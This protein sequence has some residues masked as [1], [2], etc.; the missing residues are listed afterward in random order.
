VN[1]FFLACHDFQ[2]RKSECAFFF[3]LI[4]FFTLPKIAKKKKKMEKKRFGE[5]MLSEASQER[6][7]RL[8]PRAL[9]LVLVLVGAA[10]FGPDLLL[11]RARDG[12]GDAAFEPPQSADPWAIGAPTAANAA[13]EAEA[14]AAVAA[15][16]AA[17]LAAQSAAEK[18]ATEE[19][20]E[21]G[22][23]RSDGAVAEP[24][25]VTGPAR[26]LASRVGFPLNATMAVLEYNTPQT[27]NNTL[28][29]YVVRGL[30][31]RF[32]RRVLFLQ[33]RAAVRPMTRLEEALGRGAGLEIWGS[34]ENRHVGVALRE[35]VRAADTEF[36][37]FLEKDFALVEPAPLVDAALADAVALLA[38]GV[39]DVVRL[40]SRRNPGNPEF[41]ELHFKG[42]EETVFK[43]QRNLLCNFYHFIRRPERRW[44]QHFRVCAHGWYCVQSEF[45]NWTNNPVLF[46]RSWWLDNIAVWVDA[47]KI[48]APPHENHNFEATLNVV[49]EAWSE[50]N[51]TIALGRGIFSHV[52][53]DG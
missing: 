49:P 37:L 31:G 17:A 35:I 5:K 21:T 32:A 33:K 11:W 14:A 38:S 28:Q 44:P 34:R 20:A 1:Y 51:Y 46:R 2:K 3:L 18:S 8:P 25:T 12:P 47:R 53:V 42:K 7:L 24:A 13:R 4:F 50:R 40:R 52:E 22:A 30:P 48:M 6:R 27:L 9:W 41:S 43:K 10:F 15:V 36:V 23:E 26:S 45:C 19:T 16:A 29:S 39:A